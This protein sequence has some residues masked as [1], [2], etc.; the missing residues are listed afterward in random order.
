VTK[1][2][3]YLLPSGDASEDDLECCIVFYPAR[4]EYRRALMG[5]LDFLATWL[6]WERDSEKR[7][8]DAA[9]SWKLANIQTWECTNM[10]YCED[11]MTTIE[12]LLAATHALECCGDQDIT[13]G[14]QF[15]DDI[16]D[17]VGDVPQNIID[18]GYATGV[19]D[20]AGFDDYKC[21]I[22]HLAVDH[23]EQFFR[24]ISPYISDTGIVIG[25]IGVVGALLGAILALIGLPIAFGIIM[26]VGAA[27]GIWTWIATY[28]RD[29][30]DDLADDIATNHDALA[31]AIYDG[32]GVTDAISD[33][34]AEVDSLFSTIDATAIKAVGFEPQLRAM[35]AGR[36]DQQDIAENLAD[37]G[38]ATTG[39]VCDCAG[40]LAPPSGYHLEYPGSLW[41][42]IWQQGCSNNGSTYVP[43]TGILTL[44]FNNGSPSAQTY[45]SFE[46]A[47]MENHLS[48]HGYL[49]DLL[50][51]DN[52]KGQ[53]IT[54]P[55][56]Q[57]PTKGSNKI[58]P[59]AAAWWEVGTSL[60]GYN[61]T[62]HSGSAW[63]DWVDQYDNVV[64]TDA[65]RNE[66]VWQETP[67][68]DGAG[69]P[70]SITVRIRYLVPD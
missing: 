30:V 4:D 38:Y 58:H 9:A 17:G 10:G 8:Q 16:V 2:K 50:A 49:L 53:K 6:A 26:A 27:A 12:A 39:Y 52:P 29:A 68:A 3:G 21:M 54:S 36:Y 55:T 22:S 67:D 11:L 57:A 15:T 31:C 14:L 59:S 56:N 69:T 7:A 33:F 43:A 24:Q 32:D 37:M 70:Y 66:T 41:Q 51:R 45:A 1:G 35:Y 48:Y 44:K 60:A 34:E 47:D 19:T 40:V 65:D 28:G 61:T 46:C 62:R 64:H 23:I 25:G 20:W 13:D 18:A 42:Y 63:D 5:S